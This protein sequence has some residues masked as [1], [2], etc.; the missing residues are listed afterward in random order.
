MFQITESDHELSREYLIGGMSDPDV[1]LYHSIMVNNAVILGANETQ[2][3]QELKEA[4]EFEISLA[5]VRCI[6]FYMNI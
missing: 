2:A 3:E 4:L 1:K 5:K 6:H